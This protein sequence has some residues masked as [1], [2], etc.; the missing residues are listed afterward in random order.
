MQLIFDIT[1]YYLSLLHIV[2]R[3]NSKTAKE[4]KALS[5]DLFFCQTHSA[6]LKGNQRAA[7]TDKYSY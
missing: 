3:F 7:E 2:D 5:S 6:K 1:W 4:H